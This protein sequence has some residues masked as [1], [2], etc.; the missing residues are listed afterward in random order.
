MPYGAP[1]ASVFTGG[2]MNIIKA[3]HDE[4]LFKPLF[5]DLK[6]WASWIVFLKA[7]FALP[8]TKG[9]LTLYR[10]CTGRQNPPEKPFREV[11]CPTGRR[12]GK[13]FVAALVAVFIACFFDY[14][15]FAVAG[16]SIIVA[17]IAADRRQAGVIIK[18]ILAFLHSIPM[19][20]KLIV[21]ERAESV[22]LAN[23]VTI[24]VMTCSYRSIRG[25]SYA[26][27]ICDEIAFWHDALSANPATEVLRA[28]RPGLATIP[29]S[30][31]LCISSPWARTGP[32]YEAFSRHHGRDESDVMIWS[33]PTTVM[34]PTIKQGI[35]DRDMEID[36]EM[37]RSEWLAE[38]RSDLESFLPIEAIEAVIVQGRFELPPLLGAGRS[39]R[40]FVDPSGGRRD[41]ATLAITHKEGERIILDVARAWKAPHEP[42]A[43]VW[44]MAGVLKSYGLG[45]VVGDRY[46]GAWP[47]QEFLK[48]SIRYEASEK[49]KSALYLAFLPMVLSGQVELLDLKHLKS[50]LAGL[51]RRARSGGRDSVDHGPRAHD[52][53][54]NAVAGAAVLSGGRKKIVRMITQPYGYRPE[55]TR[56]PE[57]PIHPRLQYLTA[58]EISDKGE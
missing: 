34:N 26:A 48:Y 37:A 5:R 31:L 10:Q 12:S 55:S 50:E 19:L 4:H 24:S 20:N 8:M 25:P 16:E 54:A 18:Y 11:W 35:I 46:A 3:I 42:A 17:V 23:G 47:E 49:D 36:P 7:L 51:E 56:E 57:R 27:V 44:E 22:D 32:L 9:E 1:G 39:Y 38:F 58:S 14:K 29:D 6:T 40:A 30:L 13:S 43:V 21:A 45:R 53:L 52:D 33:A 28:V 41:A 2:R 15:M